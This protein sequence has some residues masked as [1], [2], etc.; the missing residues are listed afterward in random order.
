MKKYGTAWE[1]PPL[2]RYNKT[3]T[4]IFVRN[5]IKKSERGVEICGE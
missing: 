3:N 1:V 2:S 5:F 4:A